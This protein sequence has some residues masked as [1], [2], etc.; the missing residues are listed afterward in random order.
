MG[1][2]YYNSRQT[3]GM[4]AA[5]VEGRYNLNENRTGLRVGTSV[6]QRMIRTPGVEH[7]MRYG[8]RILVRVEL[9]GGR[10]VNF[11]SNE[12]SDLTEVFGEIRSRVRG[13]RGLARMSVRNATEGWRIDRPL[14]LYADRYLS[15]GLGNLHVSEPAPQHMPF[16]WETH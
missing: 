7:R 2:R 1:S 13:E 8:D 3:E 14:K 9:P 6:R 5:I 10:E 4:D 11:V 15:R 16:P 12:L